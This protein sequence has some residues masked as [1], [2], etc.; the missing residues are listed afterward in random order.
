MKKIGLGFLAGLIMMVGVNFALA[1]DSISAEK[2]ALIKELVEVTGGKQS[3]DDIMTS[4]FAGQREHTKTMMDSLFADDKMMSP[5]DKAMFAKMAQESVER[6]TARAQ[7]YFTKKFDFDRFVNDVF[8]PS[9]AKHFTADELRDMIAFYRTPTGQKTIKVEPQ[10]MAEGMAAFSSILPDFL[11][12]M[13]KTV[14]DEMTAIK[15]KLPKKKSKRG[16]NHE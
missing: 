9:Y 6:A 2:T 5:A 14:D 3:F 7:E 1:Q 4:V 15:Q 8:I 11:E 13:K 10:I 16:P 12:F